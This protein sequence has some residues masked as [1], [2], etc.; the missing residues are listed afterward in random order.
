MGWLWQWASNDDG[1][2]D[3]VA[4]SDNVS[5]KI[6]RALQKGQR[7]VV[8]SSTHYVILDGSDFT[9]HSKADPEKRRAVRRVELVEDE[10]QKKAPPQKKT[11]KTATKKQEVKNK[12]VALGDIHLPGAFY[13]S[14]S[15]K[16]FAFRIGLDAEKC[17]SF[18]FQAET[19]PIQSKKKKKNGSEEED[20][21]EGDWGSKAAWDN[22]GPGVNIE[23]D[24]GSLTFKTKSGRLGFPATFRIPSSESD[25]L[26]FSCMDH[27][28]TTNHLLQFSKEKGEAD[29]NVFRLIW[30]GQILLDGDEDDSRPFKIDVRARLEGI[31]VAEDADAHQWLDV[32]KMEQTGDGTWVFKS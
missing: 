3:F 27:Q 2:D 23:W 21:E 22:Y 29:P 6:E 5:E 19:A 28:E 17:A 1:D 20:D 12:H 11:A 18:S 13:E 10:E 14:F 25:R 16:T 4:Y 24:F 32:S 30:E 26:N 31:D 15:W 9:Q 7:K 8:V